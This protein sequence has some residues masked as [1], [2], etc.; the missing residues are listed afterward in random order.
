VAI[1]TAP[2]AQ[3]APPAERA[4]EVRLVRPE[5]VDSLHRNCLGGW[6]LEE[7]RAEVARNV[8]L[9]ETGERTHFVAVAREGGLRGE[10]VGTA[11]LD[12]ETHPL[13]RRRGQLV[14]VSVTGPYRRRGVAR[15][16]NEAVRERAAAIT[17][18]PGGVGPMTRAMLLSNTVRAARALARAPHRV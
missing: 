6:P 16:L 4:F 12:R 3:I 2:S 14:G 15:R 17:P 7:L 13:Q 11:Y 5:D 1:P 10:V 18:V 8:S 9:A